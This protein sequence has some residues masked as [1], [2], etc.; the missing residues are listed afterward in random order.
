MALARIFIALFFVVLAVFGVSQTFNGYADTVATQAFEQTTGTVL[1]TG[2]L[3]RDIGGQPQ[4]S[5]YV[6]Y[7][8]TIVRETFTSDSIDLFRSYSESQGQEE[9]LLME[10]EVGENVTVYYDPVNPERAILR[11]GAIMTYVWIGVSVVSFLIS[12]LIA[13]SGQ[14]QPRYK[15]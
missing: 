2:I 13:I 8:Y 3:T 15:D 14:V 4:Y 10:Y 6:R 7:E 1:E 9:L 12:I 11:K 5:A